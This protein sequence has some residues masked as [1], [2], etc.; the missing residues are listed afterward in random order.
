MIQAHMHTDYQCRRADV[1]ALHL[2]VKQEAEG[3]LIRDVRSPFTKLPRI[4]VPRISG[5]VT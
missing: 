4:G 3:D 1:Q 2:S 5:Q